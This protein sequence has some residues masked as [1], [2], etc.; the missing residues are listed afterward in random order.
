MKNYKIAVIAGSMKFWNTILEVAD[1]LTQDGYI[2]LAPFKD[3]RDKLT[4]EDRDLHDKI[5]AQ[6]IDMADEMYVVNLGGYIGDSTQKEIDYAASKGTKIIYHEEMRKKPYIV[7]LCGSTRFKTEFTY[8]A[9]KLSKEGKIVLTPSIFDV[10]YPKTMSVR[11]HA[12]L[13]VLHRQKMEMADEVL[14]INKD[15]YIGEDTQKEIDWCRSH[16]IKVKYLENTYTDDE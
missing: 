13:D 7:T 4:K 3:H 15:G 10:S 11:E 8:Q 9:E 5:Q 12:V 6:R 14:I 2:V 16:N 1:R